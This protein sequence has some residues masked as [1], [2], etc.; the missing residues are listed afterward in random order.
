MGTI[1]RVIIPAATQQHVANHT[2]TIRYS[3]NYNCPLR[4]S[5]AMSPR[6]VPDLS[7]L[8]EQTVDEG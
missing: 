8:A 4:R 2:A 1:S 5:A 6:I 3:V 7:E